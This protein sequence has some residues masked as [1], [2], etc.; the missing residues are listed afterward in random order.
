MKTFNTHRLISIS[1]PSPKRYTVQ[2][3]NILLNRDSI[4]AINFDPAVDES[5]QRITAPMTT[6]ASYVKSVEDAIYTHPE[7]TD[8]Y[9]AIDVY[10]DT[11]RYTI[12][13]RSVAEDAAA[14]RDI[15][16]SL[17]PSER[18]NVVCTC[19]EVPPF[20]G[21]DGGEAFA[22][23][24]IEPALEGF[25][26]RTFVQARIMHRMVPLTRY[27]EA[28][29]RLLGNAGKMHIHR[30]ADAVDIIAFDGKGLSMANTFATAGGDDDA[31]YY[32]LAA[33]KDLGFDA[34]NDR[35]M[36]SGEA[37]LRDRLMARLKPYVNF[38][39]PVIFPTTALHLGAEAAQ[40]PF[41]LLSLTLCE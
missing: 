22:A 13:P 39:M 7:L 10:I 23:M 27:F 9:D 17:Y 41:E 12:V 18:L 11:E 2:R 24:F 6:A 3:L 34:D 36:C 25:L 16:D 30:R 33:A 21:D 15:A 4:D 5:L 8:D 31:V 38:V 19:A 28:C 26:R 20:H 1:H 32:A 29:G 37:A 14:M 40:V 35:M